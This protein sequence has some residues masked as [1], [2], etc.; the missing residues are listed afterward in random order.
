ME[1]DGGGVCVVEGVPVRHP[2]SDKLRH[3]LVNELA[4]A[5]RE[6]QRMS[7]VEWKVVSRFVWVVLRVLPAVIGTEDVV[8]HVV[9]HAVTA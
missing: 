4:D 8:G 7:G 1:R 3:Y 6:R 2:G 5:V 9:Q